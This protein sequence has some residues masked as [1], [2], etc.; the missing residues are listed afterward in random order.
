MTIKRWIPPVTPYPAEQRILKRLTRVRKLFAFLRLHRHEI[1]DEEFQDAL[2]AMYRDTGAGSPPQPPGLMCMALLLQGY[3]G[4]SDAEAVELTVMDARWQLV[5]DRLGA[6][7]PAFAQGGLQQFRSR[8]IA[9]DLDRRLLEQ[10]VK[11]ARQSKGFDHKKLPKDLRVGIDSR[12]LATAGRVEDTFNL[13]GHAGRK[14]AECAAEMS[15][16][17]YSDVC[18][19]SGAEVLL[20]PSVKAGLDVDWSDREQKDQALE[21]LVV[22]LR[23][24]SGYVARLMRGELDPLTA[25]YMEALQQVEEQDLEEQD[26]RVRIR[27]GVAPDR[28][29]SIE[30][31]EARHGRKSKSKTINGYKEHMATD[32]V[33]D[34]VLA[35]VVLP[36]NMP[37]HE[38]APTLKDDVNAQGFHID[39]LYVDRA[40]V[41]SPAMDRIEDDGGD[42]VCKP[43]RAQSSNGLALFTKADFDMDVFRKT[44]TCPAGEVQKFEFDQVV[45]FP[46]ERC[47]PCSMR[48]RCTTSTTAR[49]IQIAHDEIRQKRFRGLQATPGGRAKLRGRVPVEHRQAH[50]A[51]R[52]GNRAR[53]L[54]TR[55]NTFD[56]R[57]AGAIDNLHAAARFQHASATLATA[58]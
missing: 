16:L 22:Q 39:E 10:T 48:L 6:T 18:K 11:V 23:A 38:A 24:L 5:L 55:K 53:Y 9:H 8:L 44:I 46:T 47:Q 13:L 45:K 41:S 37:E 12:P 20:A 15:G 14:I 54:G 26:G 19:G 28:R 57:R 3:M 30:D 51:Q 4:V 43:W 32:L 35:C 21:V 52:K 36:A 17:S 1:L 40:Y 34:L 50:S 2:A 56:L 31:P 58:A 25:F 7:E 27:Q 33:N 49:S 42:V 29:I